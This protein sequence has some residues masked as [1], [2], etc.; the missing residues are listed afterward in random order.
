MYVPSL[1][2]A[3]SIAA[4]L[5][6]GLIGIQALRRPARLLKGLDLLANTPSA[7]NEI[8]AV[9]G[10]MP[11]AISLLLAESLVHTATAPV[12]VTVIA[13]ITGG[14]AAGRLFSAIVDRDF[15]AAPRLWFALELVL[16]VA[17]RTAVGLQSSS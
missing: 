16:A 3:V 9:Y 2:S 14:M 17:M 1:V 5:F 12:V 15:A 7:R 6:Y 13:T 10:G 8:R 11:I 4:I